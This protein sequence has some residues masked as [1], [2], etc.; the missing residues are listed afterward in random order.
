MRNFAIILCV[1][2]AG[3]Y[4]WDAFEKWL[5]M[6]DET[7]L[8]KG[9]ASHK[10]PEVFP[11]AMKNIIPIDDVNQ[12]I[13]R[14][15]ALSEQKVQRQEQLRQALQEQQQKQLEQ[16]KN[17]RS[18]VPPIP[19]PNQNSVELRTEPQSFCFKIGPV[20]TAKLPS[21]NRSIERAGLLEAVRVE[22]ILSADS[23]VVFI[24][25]T[26]T[27]KG[28]QALAQQMKKRGF[29][30]ASV[31]TKGP[32]LNAVQLG[33][34]SNEEQAQLFFEQAKA[35]LNMS[36]LRVTRMIGQ[37]TEQVNLIFSSL[38]ESQVQALRRVSSENRQTLQSCEF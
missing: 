33:V 15:K 21:I 38:T 27:Q 8:S 17:A 10:Q 30:N 11:S 6:P 23:F 14:E 28:A 16:A 1:I 29:Q 37:P 9:A 4:G 18:S 19:V 22:S 31:I 12:Y 5:D 34:F 3:I 25:P 13:T 20:S 24:I 35:R 7:S 2:C 26:T 32:L 36:D